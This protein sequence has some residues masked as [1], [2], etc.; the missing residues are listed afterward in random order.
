[1]STP[2]I[3]AERKLLWYALYG[4]IPGDLTST[5][6]AAACERL[7]TDIDRFGEYRTLR[8]L[9]RVM[10][11]ETITLEIARTLLDRRIWEGEQ[12]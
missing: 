3:A 12:S 4:E 7:Q 10:G 8:K 5:D 11:L 6:L 2:N 9:R 1:M